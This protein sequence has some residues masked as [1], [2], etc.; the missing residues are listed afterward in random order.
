MNYQVTLIDG[1]WEN[2]IVVIVEDIEQNIPEEELDDILF[3]AAME[4]V[5]NYPECYE[6]LQEEQIENLI[7]T[8]YSVI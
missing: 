4:H 2:E 8:E 7:M 1:N 3:D 6:D 5:N